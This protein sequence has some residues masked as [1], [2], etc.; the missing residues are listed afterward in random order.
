MG[1]EEGMV[2]SDKGTIAFRGGYA[3]MGYEPG[4]DTTDSPAITTGSERATP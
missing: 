4:E 2:W 3:S 1:L